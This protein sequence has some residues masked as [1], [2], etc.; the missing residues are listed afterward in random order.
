MDR[1][2]T[3]E[4]RAEAA[5]QGSVLDMDREARKLRTHKTAR[6]PPLAARRDV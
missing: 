5:G 2:G 4:R 1:S 3:A 6:D